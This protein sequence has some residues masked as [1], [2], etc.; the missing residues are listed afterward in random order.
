MKM[1]EEQ[2]KSSGNDLGVDGAEREAEFSRLEVEAGSVVTPDQSA[3][4]KKPEQPAVTFIHP[5]LRQ[6]FDILAPAWGVTDQE[7]TALADAYGKLAD[8]YIEKYAKDTDFFKEYELEIAAITL[9]AVFLGPRL[10]TP[11]KLESDP[12]EKKPAEGSS[13]VE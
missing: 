11:R 6:G 4:R 5:L 8:K 9:T 1:S 7:C 3:D 10:K 13:N 2:E 12:P